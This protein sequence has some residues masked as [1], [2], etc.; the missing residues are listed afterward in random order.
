[1]IGHLVDTETAIK[2]IVKDYQ[3]RGVR[4]IKHLADDLER[5]LEDYIATAA[6]RRDDVMKQN[7]DSHAE[8]TKNLQRQPK[9]EALAKQLET[10]QQ[11]LDARMEE[12]LGLCG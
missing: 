1:M 8:V 5:E 2:D 10:R 12:T 11:V 7:E 4:I 9:A 6:A 3:Q